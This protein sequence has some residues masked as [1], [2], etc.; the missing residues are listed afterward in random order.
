MLTDSFGKITCG[1]YEDILT[2]PKLVELCQERV[3]YLDDHGIKVKNLTE[4][5]KVDLR[6]NRLMVR[7]LLSRRPLLQSVTQPHLDGI[8]DAQAWQCGAEID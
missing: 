8:V 2:M 4:S 7:C 5:P 3:N 6:V 1:H